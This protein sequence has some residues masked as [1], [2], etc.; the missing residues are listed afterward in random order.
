M[1]RLIDSLNCDLQEFSE[2]QENTGS[3]EYAK[4]SNISRTECIC[5]INPVLKENLSMPAST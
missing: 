4:A 5:C 1:C 3:E 2:D